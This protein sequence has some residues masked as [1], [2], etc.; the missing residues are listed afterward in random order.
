[1]L[2]KGLLSPEPAKDIAG[3]TELALRGALMSQLM[4]QGADLL[5]HGALSRNVL[6]GVMERVADLLADATLARHLVGELLKDDADLLLRASLLAPTEL[7]EILLAEALLAEARLITLALLAETLQT[8]IAKTLA[9]AQVAKSL[10]AEAG[11]A[12]LL[13]E[14]LLPPQAGHPKERRRQR[15][16]EILCIVSVGRYVWHWKNLR[17]SARQPLPDEVFLIDS[18]AMI[19]QG[20]ARLI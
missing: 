15:L 11:A 1:M 12:E 19:N 9:E 3:L 6:G 18:G 20:G 4:Q 8:L 10:I 16:R 7:A 14:S 17:V 13:A 5:R 2:A